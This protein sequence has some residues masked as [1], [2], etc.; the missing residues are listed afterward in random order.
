MTVL[1]TVLFIAVSAAI[2]ALHALSVF[3]QSR[4]A[5]ISSYLCIAM[6]IVLFTVMLLLAFPMDTA[7]LVFLT[8]VLFY[9]ALHAFRYFRKGN[10][11]KDGE[12]A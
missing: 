7:V 11:K 3:G 2:L 4:A 6:H 9:S 10:G 8:S 12:E 1:L 5:R